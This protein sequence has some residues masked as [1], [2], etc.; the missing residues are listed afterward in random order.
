[1]TV[2][3]NYNDLKDIAAETSVISTLLVH[4][5]YIL[6]TDWLK[7]NHFSQKENAAIYWAIDELYKKGITNIDDLNLNN[8]LSSDKAVKELMA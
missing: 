6:H 2:A 4:P 5:E 7:T 8:Q 3:N 1:M